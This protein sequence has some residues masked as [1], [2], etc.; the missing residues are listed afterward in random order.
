MLLDLLSSSPIRVAIV[1]CERTC[2]PAGFVAYTSFYTKPGP[3]MAL[4][5]DESPA[6]IGAVVSRLLLRG[7]LARCLLIAKNPIFLILAL[8]RFSL[9]RVV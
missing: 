3:V 1:F 5:T 4:F 2:C 8:R 6:G 7:T 9:R